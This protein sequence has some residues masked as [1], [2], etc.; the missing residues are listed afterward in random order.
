MLEKIYKNQYYYFISLFLLS[1][2]SGHF[3]AFICPFILGDEKCNVEIF[4]NT[5]GLL[6]IFLVGSIFAP[7]I[8]TAIFQYLPVKFYYKFVRPASGKNK[9][10]FTI[11][12]AIIFGL[13]HNDNILSIIDATLHGIIFITLFFYYHERGKS[14]FFYTFLIHSLFNTYVFM[15]DDVLKIA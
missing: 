10:L 14:G 2:L 12:S 9:L 7:L 11:I 4:E 5:D 1:I 15:L 13:T 8:E 6:K 3:F